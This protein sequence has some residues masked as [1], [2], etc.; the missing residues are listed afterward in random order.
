MP[1]PSLAATRALPRNYCFPIEPA[2]KPY[3]HCC[4]WFSFTKLHQNKV[5]THRTRDGKQ[6]SA[7]LAVQ[8][9]N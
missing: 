8:I 2:R 9:T 5:I 1:S 4:C 6:A 3:M 7:P